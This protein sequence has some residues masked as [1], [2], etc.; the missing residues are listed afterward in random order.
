[1][2][3]RCTV[4]LVRPARATRVRARLTRHGKVY[5]RGRAV[6][7]GARLRLVARRPIRAGR[8]TLTLVSVDRH[9]HT[10]ISRRRVTVR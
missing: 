8:Y 4:R 2:R 1:V 7:P 10:T 3:V 9:H 6:H 5:A